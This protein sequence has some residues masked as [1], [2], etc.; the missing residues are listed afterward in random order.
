MKLISILFTL[1]SILS[2]TQQENF[3]FKDLQIKGLDFKTTELAIEKVLGKG[4]KTAIDEDNSACGTFYSDNGEK[5]YDIKYEGYTFSGNNKKGFFLTYADFDAVG[6]IQITYK[7]R[8]LSGLTTNS[9]L[10]KVFSNIKKE[11]FAH[12][13]P[14]KEEILIYTEYSETGAAFTFKND[15]LIRFRFWYL[16]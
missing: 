6:K 14:T 9:E 5:F 13:E 16:C 3:D 11:N 7:G 2:T 12:P 4:S 10:L 1:T 15:R 8:L